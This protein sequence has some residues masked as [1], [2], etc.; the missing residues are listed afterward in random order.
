MRE[1]KA[2]NI[3][4]GTNI[5]AARERAGYTQEELSELLGMTPNHLSAIERGVS[6]ISLDALQKLCLLLGISA[7]YVLFGEPAA[8]DEAQMLA[9][10]IAEL[11][12]SR[13]TR[14]K[15]ILSAVLE[16]SSM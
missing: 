10:Q 4:I 12:P 15:H 8:D 16:L 3:Q 2:I 14:V 13:R 1:K 7:D 6:G 11:E 9:R 5:Q